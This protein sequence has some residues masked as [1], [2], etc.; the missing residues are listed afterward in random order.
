MSILSSF[1][2]TQ[3]LKAI[4]NEFVSHEPEMQAV[5]LNETRV[6]VSEVMSW[7]QSKIDNSSGEKS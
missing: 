5:I 4:E 3:L 6:F 1:V 7:V 2:S